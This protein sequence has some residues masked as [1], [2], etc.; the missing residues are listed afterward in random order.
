MIFINE[1][2]KA[3]SIYKPYMEDFIK[4]F[5]CICPFV[6]EEIYHLLGHDDLIT[7]AKWPTYDES[8]LVKNEVKIAVQVNGKMRD[9]ILVSLDEDEE[10]VKAKALASEKVKNFTDGKTI[11]KFIY[12][13][14]KI[15]NIVAI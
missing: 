8:K 12:V 2:Y 9:T 15:V 3:N 11:K 1:V 10:S 4:M 6:G 14:G 5:D 7:Y 13:K